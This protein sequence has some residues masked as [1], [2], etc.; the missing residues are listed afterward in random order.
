MTTK[1]ENIW[2]TQHPDG[3]W[4]KKKENRERSSGKYP[5]QKEAIDSAV[6]QAK[7]EGVE[8]IVQGK[9]GKIRSKDSYGNDPNPPKDKEH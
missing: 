2:V 8:V 1:K 5:T 3:G 4:Q 7:K 6:E 9:D